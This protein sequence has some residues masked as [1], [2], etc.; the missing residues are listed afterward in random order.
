MKTNRFLLGCASLM[1]LMSLS[2]PAE[3]R[4][5]HHHGHGHP[6]RGGHIAFGYDAGPPVFWPAPWEEALYAPPPM[7][8]P[9]TYVP[10]ATNSTETQRYCREYNGR[11]VINGTSQPTYGTACWQP[12]GSWEI[13]Q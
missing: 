10:P 1:A 12:D 13:Q 8:E 2:M 6:H 11:A 4:G 9:V 7:P 3:A 5:P